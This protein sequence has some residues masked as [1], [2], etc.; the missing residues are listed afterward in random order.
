MPSNHLIL[1]HS[2]LLPSMFPSIRVFFSESALHIRQPKYCSFSFSF[3]PSTEYSGLISFKIDWFDCLTVQGTLKSVLQHHSLKAS[4]IC[5]SLLYGPALTSVHDQWKNHRF[6]Y[7][8]LCL[9]CL[10]ILMS[11]LFSMLSRI[12]QSFSSRVQTSL[13]FVAVVTVYSDFGAQEN[14][15]CHGFHFFPSCVCHEMMDQMP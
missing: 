5:H 11:V 15:I 9:Q 4:F 8:N 3:S 13:N 14:K 6:D 10:N 1:C 2:L 7:M 12:C